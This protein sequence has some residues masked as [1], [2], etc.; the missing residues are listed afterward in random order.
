M[1]NLLGRL[2]TFLFGAAIGRAAS[3]AIAPVLE[4]VKQQAWKDNPN[5]VLDPGTAAQAVA[6]GAIRLSEAQF[7]AVRSGV[8]SNRFGVLWRLAQHVP[9][10]SEARTLRRRTKAD[11]SGREITLEQLHHAYAK[12]QIE[13]QYWPGLDALVKDILS[14]GEL[15]AAIHRGLV[16]DPGLLQGEQPQPPFTV[17]A[18]PVY[19]INAVQEAMGSGYDKDR[20]GVLVGLQGL[21]MGTHEAAQAFFRGIITHGDYIRAFNESNSRNEWARPVLDLSRQIPTSRDFME[22]ALR[23][24]HDFDWAA[25]QAER[26]GMSREDAFLIYQNAGRPLNL[27]QI[28]QAIGWG[29]KYNPGPG[30]DPD[31]W[32]QAVLL[33]AVRPEYYEMQDALKYIVPSA[34]AIRSLAESGVWDEAKTAAR[35]KQ[36]GWIPEDADQ[37]AFAWTQPAAAT[38]NPFVGRAQTQLWA[39]IFNDYVRDRKIDRAAADNLLAPLVP[40]ARPR[41]QILNLWTTIRDLTAPPAQTPEDPF[42]AKA[43]NQLWTAIHRAYAVK[44]EID[45]ATA[46]S[47]LTNLISDAIVR[48]VVLERWTTER[49]L[50]GRTGPPA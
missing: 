22:N 31:P 20:L 44:A 25:Q 26:H 18:Y 47:Y 46:D 7:D 36:A 5:K 32:H 45:E 12:A 49:N 19:P 17:D 10:V 28:S 15:A 40:G 8:S 11:G 30:D 39:A 21:P 34:F 14:P 9:G 29:A 24:H 38:A 50:G 6:Q 27:H 42:I 37:V 3:D 23:G 48:A 33:G 2:Q 35:L 16:P 4:P 43:D 41:N 13:P 1:A